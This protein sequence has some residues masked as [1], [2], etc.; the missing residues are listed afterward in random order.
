MSTDA[1]HGAAVV[2]TSPGTGGRAAAEAARARNA[3]HLL[4]AGT[5]DVQGG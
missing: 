3:M 4:I 2:R 5:E 1:S